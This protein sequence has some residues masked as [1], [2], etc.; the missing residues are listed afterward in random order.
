MQLDYFAHMLKITRFF[1]LVLRGYARPCLIV[2]AMFDLL[3]FLSI[4]FIYA[5]K[6]GS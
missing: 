6:L 4:Y 1:A 5:H 3:I 2:W